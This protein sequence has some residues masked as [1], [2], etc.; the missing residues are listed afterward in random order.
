[1]SNDIT[2]RFIECFR[3]LKELNAI[4]S[5]RQFCLNLSYSPQSWLK[6]LKGERDITLD[7]LKKA[8][9]V[10]EFN[11]DFLIS[12]QGERLRNSG[13]SDEF[14]THDVENKTIVHIPITAKAGYG[15]QLNNPVFASELKFYSLPMDYYRHGSFRSFEVEG[16]SMEPVLNSGEIVVCT[17]LDDQ[18]LWQNNIKTGYV[19][20]VITQNDIVVKRVINLLKDEKTLQLVSD[21]TSYPDIIVQQDDIHEIWL[22]KMKIS[23]FA[24]SR[25]NLRQEMI[26]NY[27]ELK[28]TIKNQSEIIVRLNS[29]VEK[30]LLKN[31]LQ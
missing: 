26:E 21:N 22:V 19:Y 11:P 29:V 15:D 27:S 31:R 3:E 1:M 28:K 20:V 18:A 30:I 13:T 16:D 25:V 7:L 5:D 23:S 2:K 14:Q 24:H 10:Y 9:E 17:K 8:T 12:G 4:K 6:I